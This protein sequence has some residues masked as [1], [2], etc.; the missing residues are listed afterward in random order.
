MDKELIKSPIQKED[1]EESKVE[2]SIENLT[3]KAQKSDSDVFI[4]AFLKALKGEKGDRGE[5]G[6]KG[7]DGKD[8]KL[9]DLDKKDIANIVYGIVQDRLDEDTDEVVSD[10]LIVID[11]KLPEKIK[12]ALEEQKPMIKEVVSSYL[13]TL[14]KNNAEYENKLEKKIESASNILKSDV[15]KSLN[16]FWELKKKE[17][18]KQY[19]PETAEKIVER[20]RGKISWHDLVERPNVISGLAHLVDVSIE[21][22]PTNGQV[23]K[24]NSTSKRW[25]PGTDNN[26]GG[27]GGVTVE[28]PPETVDSSTVSFT[29]TA[30][31]KWVVS[32]GITYFDGAGYTYSSLTVTMDTPPTMFIRAI[33]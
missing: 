8:Y 28:T 18:A 13:E 3:E 17:I 22:E 23:L 21:S 27:G 26:S 7:D 25:T 32:D 4:S 2:E 16:T 19:R 31:P 33:I 9:T 30:E 1:I 20:V 6:D 24:W 15:Q 10:A 12:M 5:K 14:K 29:V 11:K